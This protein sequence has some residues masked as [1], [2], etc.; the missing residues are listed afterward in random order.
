MRKLSPSQIDEKLVE[1]VAIPS[2]HGDVDVGVLLSSV[3][4]LEIDDTRPLIFPAC[5]D[6]QPSAV[7]PAYEQIPS[8]DVEEA[9]FWGPKVAF[10]AKAESSGCELWR[11]FDEECR[12]EGASGY[13]P[14]PAD[15]LS[16][17]DA[18]K[19]DTGTLRAISWKDLTAP[20]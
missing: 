10:E 15:D 11:R 8:V 17:F 9:D 1:A 5:P 20:F 3:G 14:I 2:R 16:A 19:T 6:F 18:P 12:Q 4:A 13:E 7:I